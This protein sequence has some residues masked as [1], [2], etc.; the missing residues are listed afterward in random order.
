MVT[1]LINYPYLCNKKIPVILSDIYRNIT[2]HIFIIPGVD[3]GGIPLSPAPQIFRRNT[4]FAG[5]V[6]RA[7]YQL[8]PRLLVVYSARGFLAPIVCFEGATPAFQSW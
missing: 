1:I 6:I 7:D 2:V 4:R 8:L 5:T 3:L